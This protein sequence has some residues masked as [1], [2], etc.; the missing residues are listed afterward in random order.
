MDCIICKKH[1]AVIH[2]AEIVD[3]TIKKL[4][5][6]EQ[7]AVEKGLGTQLSFSMGDLLGGMTESPSPRKAAQICKRCEMSLDEFR[8]AGRLGCSDCYDTFGESL[9]NMFEQIH[10]STKHKGKIPSHLQS[11]YYK[12]ENITHME[13]EMKD[14]VKHEDFEKAAFLRDEIHKTKQSL[15]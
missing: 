1:K 3:G 12:K 15:K 11:E 4:D 5:L 6:C 13:Q 14:A 8:K 9:I 7:C 10:R 2:Y